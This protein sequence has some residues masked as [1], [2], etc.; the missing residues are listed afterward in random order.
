MAEDKQSKLEKIAIDQ[1]QSQLTKNTYTD[2]DPSKNYTGKHTRALSDDETPV[3]GKGT[4]VF[5][6]TNNGGS[7]V[8][9]YG[10]MQFAGSG[11]KAALASNKFDPENTYKQP[12]TSKNI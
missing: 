2:A 3:N 7:S 11:R 12:D 9:I 1:R 5:M 10:N 6:D 8:D 4:G